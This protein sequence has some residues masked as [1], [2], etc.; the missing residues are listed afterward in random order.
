MRG[1]VVTWAR[2]QPA[3]RGQSSSSGIKSH[4]KPSP[5]VSIGTSMQNVIGN[6]D[7]HLG[8]VLPDHVLILGSFI[9][10]ACTI[11]THTKKNC[12]K[13]WCCSIRQKLE[14]V[15]ILTP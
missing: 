6:I 9:V 5:P 13:K 3:T 10:W 2:Q 11:Y 8:K 4:T 12:A 14:A 1:G 15:D 7:Q